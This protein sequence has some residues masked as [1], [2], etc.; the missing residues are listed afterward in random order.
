M[1]EHKREIV[2][3]VVSASRNK[4]ITVQVTRKIKHPLLGKYIRRSSKIHAHDE[5]NKVG[6]G[7]IV[8]IQESRPIS[9]TKSWTLTEVIEKAKAQ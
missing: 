3:T 7:D 6:L 9:K 2:G 5:E 8:K 1:S 4:S